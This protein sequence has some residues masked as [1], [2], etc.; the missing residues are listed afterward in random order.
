[1]Q[2]RDRDAHA[3]ACLSPCCGAGGSALSDS[4]VVTESAA[5]PGYSAGSESQPVTPR[6]AA[7]P[8]HSPPPSPRFNGSALGEHPESVEFEAASGASVSYEAVQTGGAVRLVKSVN[9][10]SCILLADIGSPMGTVTSLSYDAAAMHVREQSGA[11]TVVRAPDVGRV[12]GGLARLAARCGVAHSLP[13]LSPELTACEVSLGEVLCVRDDAGGVRA[14]CEVDGGWESEYSELVGKSGVVLRVEERSDESEWARV[15]L[16]HQ[17]G[18]EVTWPIAA[19]SHGYD[20]DDTLQDALKA[21]ELLSFSDP[22]SVKEWVRRMRGPR[23]Y[24]YQRLRDV[25]QTWDSASHRNCTWHEKQRLLDTAA[26]LKAIR[27]TRKQVSAQAAPRSAAVIRRLLA[28]EVRSDRLAQAPLLH[29]AVEEDGVP[30]RMFV[31]KHYL[32]SVTGCT[33]ALWEKT[34]LWQKTETEA[35]RL[36]TRALLRGKFPAEEGSKLIEPL[37]NGESPEYLVAG[38]ALRSARRLQLMPEEIHR[39]VMDYL[40]PIHTLTALRARAKQVVEPQDEDEGVDLAVEVYMQALDRCQTQ[41]GRHLATGALHFLHRDKQRAKTCFNNAARCASSELSPPA[42]E[43]ARPLPYLDA[44]VATLRARG[45]CGS[46]SDEAGDSTP[47][48][49]SID[50]MEATA[51]HHTP[52]LSLSAPHEQDAAPADPSQAALDSVLGSS[53]VDAPAPDAAQP[54]TAPEAD[55]ISAWPEEPAQA[56]EDEEVAMFGEMGPELSAAAAATSA[57]VE[58]TASLSQVASPAPMSPMWSEQTAPTPEPLS[59]TSMSPPQSP[60]LSPA[61]PCSGGASDW[62]SERR[63]RDGAGAGVCTCGE[64]EEQSL[65]Y[66]SALAA[67]TRPPEPYGSCPTSYSKTTKWF[68]A[69]AAAGPD[70]A[71]ADPDVDY[72]SV[73]CAETLYFMALV[74]DGPGEAARMLQRAERLHFGACA[75][76]PSNACP[77]VNGLVNLQLGLTRAA[78]GD[79]IGAVRCFLVAEKV[80][81]SAL[82]TSWLCRITQ[83]LSGK[84]EAHTLATSRLLPLRASA[85]SQTLIGADAGGTASLYYSDLTRMAE[86][87]AVVYYNLDD[88]DLAL[89]KAPKR[90]SLH[91]LR[92]GVLAD[93]GRYAEAIVSLSR[94]I[95]HTYQAP[96]LLQRAK[97]KLVVGDEKGA[98][99]DLAACLLFQPSNVAA[100]ALLRTHQTAVPTAEALKDTFYTR[101]GYVAKAACLYQWLKLTPNSPQV[102]CRVSQFFFRLGSKRNVHNIW[103]NTAIRNCGKK[104]EP[105]FRGLLAESA[106]DYQ[107]AAILF[108]EAVRNLPYEYECHLMLAYTLV[109]MRQYEASTQVLRCALHLASHPS[110]CSII[111]NNIGYNYRCLKMYHKALA[112]FEK[113][114]E[115]IPHLH[116]T[117]FNPFSNASE[118]YLLMGEH[119]RAA[120]EIKLGL[121]SAIEVRPSMLE[122]LLTKGTFTRADD[123]FRLCTQIKELDPYNEFTYRYSAA[124]MWDMGRVSAGLIELNE[125]IELTLGTHALV[126]RGEGWHSF[127][128]DARA[129]DNLAMALLLDA[130]NEPALR[131]HRQC[132]QMHPTCY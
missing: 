75:D 79:L 55:E 91:Q 127:S 84:V 20:C 93:L 41:H 56:A 83:T 10:K 24:T 62:L 88:I 60:P 27:M 50:D 58:D 114:K 69:V 52:L 49:A 47:V 121:R 126:M 31:Y 51:V 61:S 123:I 107:K 109:S 105:L 18:A 119:R 71:A 46:C 102:Y 122:E 9:G 36:D 38:W 130:H 100:A 22:D 13:W 87:R 118:I 76:S 39:M 54:G 30:L 125:G 48:D 12:V 101:N 29:R 99:E 85:R 89:S 96:D 45:S 59:P 97:L 103:C 25:V 106:R 72:D 116:Y 73:S 26:K 86:A 42:F 111:Y 19:L 128:D 7:A 115:F 68:E 67:T 104:W 112:Y 4:G 6:T 14:V 78:C 129:K 33:P 32:L 77:F 81:S 95:K 63:A 53:W 16:R 21:V 92:A 94:S 5:S 117:F 64:T 110:H 124:V 120:E 35:A 17:T 131:L 28:H 40:L 3:D 2:T 44:L 65:Q 11:G 8:S 57:A 108:K 15:R 113:S 90:P 74:A 98:A 66:L 132:E 80:M 1:M 37:S 43:T 82:A 34:A 70:P 23:V